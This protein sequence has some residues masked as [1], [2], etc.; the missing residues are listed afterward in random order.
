MISFGTHRLTLALLSPLSLALPL[1]LTL[2]LTGSASAQ[3][4]GDWPQWGKN[5]TRNMVSTVTGIPDHFVAGKFKG[6]TEEIDMATTKNIKWI[7]KLGSQ[8]YGNPT[9]AD[10][11]VYVQRRALP[12]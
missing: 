4:A 7:A 12:R 9:V 2:S 10:G 11:K 6:N 8:A 5:M 3:G 1:S